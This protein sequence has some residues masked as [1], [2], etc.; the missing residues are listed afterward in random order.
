M[1][2]LFADPELPQ[3]SG[4]DR[5]LAER[6]RPRNL[7]DFVGQSRILGENA[8]LRAAL[9][10][11]EIPSLIL[12]GPP[13]CGKTTLAACLAHEL[14]QTFLSYSAV[15]VGVKE[16]KQVMAD[17]GRLRAAGGRAPILFLD[18]IHRFNKA[19]QDALLPAVES[20]DVVLIGATT[21]NPSFEV[22]AALLSRCRVLV[23]EQLGE[24]DLIEVMTR[25]LQDER[26]LAA[27]Q[28][29]ADSAALQLCAQRCGG[30][31]RFALNS[32]ELAARV[33][34]QRSTED[35][36]VRIGGDDVQRVLAE[37]HLHYDKSGEEHFNL[38]SA[39]HKS[40]RNSDAQAGIYW[41]TRMLES[42]EDPMYVA[43][44]LVRFASEDV[45]LADPQA[46]T[47]ATAASL[48]VERIGM[49]EGALALCQAAVYLAQAPKSNAIYLAHAEARKTIREG[50]TDPVPLHLRNAATSLMKDIGYGDGYRYAHDESGGVAEM[51]CLPERLEDRIF[52]R[53]LDRGFEAQAA[54]RLRAA[55][56]KAHRREDPSV[57]APAPEKESD[58]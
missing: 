55:W 16:L 47:Q 44:R 9:E 20:G 24:E 57:P 29:A 6:M 37:V 36:V 48:A 32:L 43:R 19:Q 53:P 22:N 50:F 21:E 2:D 39:L 7:D 12:W 13:G 18:E 41:L 1:S 58:Q 52:Y 31:A 8:S 27:S 14:H 15:R 51:S 4:G 40:L 34:E 46:L 45:G 33:A 42:G 5:P 49:P 17:A 10:A 38:I 3:P 23:L 54:E 35:G 30:D 26:G 56:R 25:A 11:G 28:V